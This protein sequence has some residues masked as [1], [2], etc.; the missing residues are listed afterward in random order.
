M[1]TTRRTLIATALATT[2]AP[3]LAL[4]AAAAPAATDPTFAARGAHRVA[5]HRLDDAC[6][7]VGALEKSPE[8][9]TVAALKAAER[10]RD[11]IHENEEGP[12]FDALCD[13]AKGVTP[14]GVSPLLQHMHDFEL[15]ER[16][17]Y[18]ELREFVLA[19]AA[20]AAKG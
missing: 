5:W 15:I 10:E 9:T 11:A 2:V 1:A 14:D 4:V 18:M 19:I 13:A 12:A 3:T 16:L 20:A 6:T 7:K 8:T 17:D